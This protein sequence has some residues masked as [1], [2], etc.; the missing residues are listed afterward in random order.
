M[1]GTMRPR[2]S[3]QGPHQ[4]AR[5]DLGEGGVVPAVD[6]GVPEG[7]GGAHRGAHAR[8]GSPPRSARAASRR[9]SGVIASGSHS[10]SRKLRIQ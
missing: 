2:L 5:R 6:R 4:E 10:P 7:D 1:N 9:T 3:S 8:A